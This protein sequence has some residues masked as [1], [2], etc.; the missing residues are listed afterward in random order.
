MEYVNK[1]DFAS[2]VESL[3][4]Q[5]HVPGLSLAVMQGDQIFSA[6]YGKASLETLLPCTPD[7]LF[8]IASCA[9]SMTAAS[10]ALLVE[11][12]ENFPEV[13]YD[14][15]MSHLLPE[16]FVMSEPEYTEGITVEDV[17]S[18]RTGMAP[19]EIPFRG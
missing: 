19:Y 11:D 12:N 2:E 8:D 4:G 14:A 6:G 1:P 13:K 9:K 15:K 7:T 5:Y 18:H 17:L 10:V 3:M 16:D